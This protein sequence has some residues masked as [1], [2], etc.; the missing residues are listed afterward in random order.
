MAERRILSEDEVVKLLTEWAD[1]LRLRSGETS[2]AE[3]ALRSAEWL[4]RATNEKLFVYLHRR[5]RLSREDLMALF[6]KA[7]RPR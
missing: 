1:H 6:D 2:E 3:A 4:T 7:Q 5:D